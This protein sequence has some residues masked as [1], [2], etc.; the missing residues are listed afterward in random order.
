MTKLTSYQKLKK[1]VKELKKE[2][3]ALVGDN[4]MEKVEVQLKYR[5]MNDI[6]KV[7]W[8]GNPR[9]KQ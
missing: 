4:L 3:N 7:I 1:E 8:Q 5:L 6:E 2:I 9:V